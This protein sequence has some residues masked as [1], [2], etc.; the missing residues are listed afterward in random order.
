MAREVD[1]VF[2]GPFECR[3]CGFETRATVQ[4][5]GQRAWTP[6]GPREAGGYAA[7]GESAGAVAEVVASRTLMFVR[8]PS[9]GRRD[10]S[11]G[12]Y[13]LQVVL[14]A[15]LAGTAAAV[16]AL[17]GTIKATGHV[18]DVMLPVSIATGIAV[19]A[20]VYW[21]YR[22]AWVRVDERVT[23]YPRAP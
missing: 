21:T 20:S 19:A 7:H 10:P 17:L 9:C 2:E 22:R 3:R 23:L 12:M 16:L 14:G 4:A 8:C 6:G 5:T 18:S 13:R 15:L 11:A 1:D